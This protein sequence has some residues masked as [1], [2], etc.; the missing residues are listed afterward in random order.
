MSEYN[1]KPAYLITNCVVKDAAGM[2]RYS[3]AVRPL[4]EKFG[5]RMISLERN[6]TVLEGSVSPSLAIVKFPSI[7]QARAFYDDP[8]YAP[9]K[10]MRINATEGSTI[11]AEGL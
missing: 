1:E 6:V 3:E 8:E 9:I 10:Q 5:G 11:L 2:T 7:E 4:L